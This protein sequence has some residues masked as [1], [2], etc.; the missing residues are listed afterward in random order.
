MHVI[1]GT[2]DE[3]VLPSM[4]PETEWIRG[5]AKRKVSPK[6][7][8]ARIQSRLVVLLDAW[9][10]GRGEV[11]SEW[12]FR[13]A[14]SPDAR[15]P[16]VPDV[17]YVSYERMSGVSREALEA[18][19]FA[20]DVAF[21]IRSPGDNLKD[22]E[23]KIR[24]YRACG[25]HAVVVIDPLRSLVKVVDEY[26]VTFLER[27]DVFEHPALPGFRLVLADLFSALDLPQ[28]P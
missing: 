3:I 9:A 13:L 2:P 22:L 7:S 4:K 8:H 5:R 14:P 26:G 12:R 6:Q 19:E 23:E 27:D 15:R 1:P 17:C 25:A 24:V 18:P 10:R 20:P 28:R 21:E 16:L 11:G